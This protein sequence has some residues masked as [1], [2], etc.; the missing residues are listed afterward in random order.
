MLDQQ[1]LLKLASYRMPFG[2]YK[3]RLLIDLPEP[4]VVWF[5]GKGFPAGELGEMLAIVLEIKVNGL[6]YLFEPLRTDSRPNR[7]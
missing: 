2:K 5:A 7:Q 4:Y 3:S 1:Q 6:E